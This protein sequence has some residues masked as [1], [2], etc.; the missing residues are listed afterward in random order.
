M[1]YREKNAF[2]EGWKT[3]FLEDG[4]EMPET[5]SREWK[6]VCLPHN[7]EDYQGY[8]RLSHG[9]LHGTAWYQNYFTVGKDWKNRIFIEFEGAGS[10]MKLW[11]NGI[12]IGEHK[13]GRTSFSAELTEALKPGEENQILVRTDHPEKIRDLPWVCGGCWGTPNTEGSQPLGLFRPAAV[14]DTGDVR[15]NPFGVEIRYR[16]MQDDSVE[17]CTVTELKNLSDRE[18]DIVLEQTLIGPDG[19]QMLQHSES[20]RLASKEARKAE[21]MIG[22]LHTYRLWSLEDPF[23]YRLQTVIRIVRTEEASDKT[24]E[25]FGI[26]FLEWE[27][28]DDSEDRNADEKLLLEK[29]SQENEFFVKRKSEPGNRAEI[30]AG[31]VRIRKSG[32]EQ[33]GIVLEVETELENRECAARTVELESFVQTYNRTKSIADLKTQLTLGPGERRIV[34]QKTEELQFLDRWSREKPY[35]YQV[36]S[37]LR[38]TE[39]MSEELMRAWTPFG[40]DDEAVIVNKAY[41]YSDDETR[42]EER[43]HRFFLNG[44]PVLIQG[45]CEYEHLLGCDHAFTDEQIEARMHQIQAAGFNAFREAHCPHNLRY[46]EYCEKHGLLYW[47]QMGAHLY[48]DTPD[49]RKN[50]ENLMTEWVK[51]RRNSPSLILWGLQNESMLPESFAE[52]MTEKIC[53]MDQQTPE[54]RKTTTCN[55]GAGSCWN[56]PQNWSG[57]YG[58][59]VEKYGEEIKKQRLIGEYGQYRVLSLHEEGD[60]HEKQNAGGCVSEELF[61]YSLGAKLC[62]LEKS[63]DSVC[64]HFQWIFSSHANPGREEIYCLDGKGSNAAGV[65]NNKG[66]LTCWGEP[67]DAYY[68]YRAFC[69]SAEKEPMVYI[70]SHTWPDRFQDGKSRDITVY[71]NCDEVALYLD[72]RSRLTERKKRSGRMEPFVFRNVSVG[73]GLLYAVGYV[74]GREAAED[75]VVPN[76]YVLTEN[77]EKAF[78]IE[79]GLLLCG[80]KE[81]L[82]RVNCGGEDYVDSWGNLW[83]ADRKRQDRSCGWFSWAMEYDGLEDDY[84]SV[85]H[86]YEPVFN[87]ADQELFRTYRYGREKLR[88]YFPVEPGEYTVELYFT[89]PWYGMDGG[90]CR[91]WRLFDVA[92]NGKIMWKD[93]DIWSEAGIRKVLKKKAD[94]HAEREI[95]V[96]FPR[97]GSYQA[98]ISA[99]AVSKREN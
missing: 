75:I 83:S 22:R 68:M 4:A 97:V 29:P 80:R 59:D 44:E 64:G 10:Y 86:C 33:E 36:S 12:Y 56:V 98:V 65:V 92:L 94:I 69:T 52:A 50:Y 62:E 15:I 57:T 76:G 28:F 99:I 30:V 3:V 27:N 70:V 45:T 7:W 34:Y 73:V 40:L 77:G 63:R 79:P 21:Q 16:K 48:F 78:D 89:E 23:L 17:I 55:G 8:R 60:M 67:T 66:L 72:Y 91:G 96:S 18:Q 46:L 14:Y 19:L 51:E 85:G 37:T 87:T 11:C 74:N 39:E 47:A 13:G 90:N 20:C 53:T 54:Q 6:E 38:D 31:G 71:S 35:Y 61:C 93:L 32:G 82:Y 2:N 1:E 41:P 95:C 26:R 43:K 49:F 24:T 42:E 9:N 25:T 88:Y 5:G 81:T 84:T 58:G